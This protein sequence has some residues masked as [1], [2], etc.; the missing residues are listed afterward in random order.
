MI[1]NVQ[2]NVFGEPLE[3][4][5]YSP[6]TGWHRDGYCNFFPDDLGKHLVCA[7]VTQDFLKFSKAKGNDLS[8]PNEFFPGLKAG[9]KWCICL[10]RVV[11][12]FNAGHP[13]KVIL[14][15]THINVLEIVPSSLLQKMASLHD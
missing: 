4:C 14:A 12:A 8:T 11:E 6:K 2:L 3:P 1:N 7:E 13:P 15:S 5:C 9:E 10:M